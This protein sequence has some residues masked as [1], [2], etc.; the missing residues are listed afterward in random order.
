MW[1]HGLPFEVSWEANEAIGTDDIDDPPPPYTQLPAGTVLR[2]ATPHELTSTLAR[3][4]AYNNRIQAVRLASIQ[5]LQYTGI[6]GTANQV[7]AQLARPT[8]TRQAEYQQLPILRS[9]PPPCPRGGVMH[10]TGEGCSR[11]YT[12]NH[13]G[14]FTAPS[15][16]LADAQTSLPYSNVES[17]PPLVNGDAA[18]SVFDSE[19]SPQT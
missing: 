2:I 12:R 11:C 8:S 9:V 1:I 17:L 4:D 3:T 19:P 7:I 15:S 14:I 13:M 16:A 6:D 10:F 5:R 18:I